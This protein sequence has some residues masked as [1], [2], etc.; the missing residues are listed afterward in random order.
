MTSM[1]SRCERRNA[2]PS[3]VLLEALASTT[4]EAPK[5]PSSSS[6]SSIRNEVVNSG[7]RIADSFSRS[8]G[9]TSWYWL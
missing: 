7:R 3:A 1:S 5:N 2:R 9:A 8:L 6:Q 4:W